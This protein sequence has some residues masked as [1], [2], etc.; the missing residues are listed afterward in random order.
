MNFNSSKQF[1]YLQNITFN[2]TELALIKLDRK[3]FVINGFI[4]FMSAYLFICTLIYTISK[5]KDKLRFE[6][7]LCLM[8]NIANILVCIIILVRIIFWERYFITCQVLK[9]SMFALITASRCSTHF[10]FRSRYKLMEKSKKRQQRAF[11]FTVYTIVASVL[12]MLIFYL[13]VFWYEGQKS[14]VYGKL[15]MLSVFGNAFLFLTVFVVQMLILLLVIIKV[16]RHRRNINQS[17]PNIKCLKMKNLLKRMIVTL[18][19]Y[20]VSDVSLMVS[21]VI[22]TWSHTWLPAFTLINMNMN[23]L[24]IICSF[25]DY[26]QRL[27]PLITKKK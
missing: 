1:K 2:L 20:A 22:I 15:Y 19:S 13:T 6:N 18:F 25:V 21:T 23:C 9:T 27:M 11:H 16:F 26:K 4:S 3:Q 24:S 7:C 8:N 14:C 10:L 5:R 12:Q 17:N